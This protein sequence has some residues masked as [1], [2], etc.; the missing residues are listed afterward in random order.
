[1]GPLPAT[2]HRANGLAPAPLARLLQ[3]HIGH[4]HFVVLGGGYV[5]VP[6]CVVCLRP[7][8]TPATQQGD[9]HQ[10]HGQNFLNHH[11]PSVCGYTWRSPENTGAWGYNPSNFVRPPATRVS[12]PLSWPRG[13]PP[14]RRDA[15]FLEVVTM[16]FQIILH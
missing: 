10:S 13:L 2:P 3:E 5:D 6:V 15:M 12:M 16:G 4:P 1:M 14:F 7:R 8:R 9:G 11:S